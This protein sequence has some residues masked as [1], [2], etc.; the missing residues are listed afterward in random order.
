MLQSAKPMA[1]PSQ[2]LDASDE[3]TGP[4]LFISTTLKTSSFHGS[5]GVSYTGAISIPRKAPSP[6]RIVICG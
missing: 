6:P 1:V 3:T 5:P 2:T 4:G